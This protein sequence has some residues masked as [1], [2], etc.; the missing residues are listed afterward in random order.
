MRIS[1]RR[2]IVS[3]NWELTY[4]GYDG[5]GS[6]RQLFNTAGAVTDTYAYDAFGNTV[7]HTGSMLN[8]FQY[9]GE[10][11]DSTLGMYNLRAR[12]LNPLPGRLVTRD[13]EEGYVKIPATLHQYL[14]AVADPVNRVDPRGR[15]TFEYTESLEVSFTN[16]GL[17]H[18]I[19]GGLEMN[20][21]EVEAFIEA[22]V[23]QL[24]SE[25]AAA[26]RT[27]APF[28]VFFSM[29]QLGNVPWAY[30]VFILTDTLLSIGTYF[31][32]NR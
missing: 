6:V 19:E 24:L 23:R 1:Q 11:F 31:P 5:G 18:L 2:L 3:P 29:S 20:Q 26:V 14:Y 30:R 17:Q 16:H 28:D 25:Y 32:I 8:E 4:Y 21:A 12:Y 27:G 7:A 10:Q 9:R 13:P 22:D 15:N